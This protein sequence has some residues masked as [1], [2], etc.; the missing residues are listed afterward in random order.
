MGCSS[1]QQQ[2]QHQHQNQ[3][4]H[5]HNHNHNHKSS[6]TVDFY[7]STL[8]DAIHSAL[9]Q[10]RSL[11]SCTW[12]KTSIGL[13]GEVEEE[14]G[15]TCKDKEGET[16]VE[17]KRGG[18]LHI[19]DCSSLHARLSTSAR[20]RQLQA[21][22]DELRGKVGGSTELLG[23]VGRDLSEGTRREAREAVASWTRELRSCMDELKS[24]SAAD[25][26]AAAPPRFSGDSSSSSSSSI[27][28]GQE[29]TEHMRY[30]IRVDAASLDTS[31]LM[32]V[33]HVK[34]RP[35]PVSIGKGGPN[36]MPPKNKRRRK[37][38]I[39]TVSSQSTPLQTNHFPSPLP[40]NHLSFLTSCPLAAP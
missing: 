38:T 19:I 9:R 24:A 1:F 20:V 30:A 13:H 2:H 21:M 5:K 34:W 22:V 8:C 6:T 17:A 29:E 26:A 35:A 28:H 15:W 37:H 31:Q 18:E 7:P 23:M 33:N 36:T 27:N 39:D 16:R 40:S 12:Q 3:Q 25:R 32:S 11:C 10:T 14:W 4:K